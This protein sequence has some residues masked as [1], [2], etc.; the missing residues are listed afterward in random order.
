MKTY[1]NI[2]S[3][4]PTSSKTSKTGPARDRA[5]DPEAWTDLTTWLHVMQGIEV[6][7]DLTASEA[8]AFLR[9]VYLLRMTLLRSIPRELP[10]TLDV[11]V[12]R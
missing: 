9:L 10:G 12:T 7:A 4:Y 6:V 1:V 2:K 3:V 11:G 5:G 8:D